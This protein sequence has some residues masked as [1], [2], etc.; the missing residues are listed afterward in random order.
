MIVRRYSK[1]RTADSE[2]QPS[3]VTIRSYLIATGLLAVLTATAHAQAGVPG[4]R[5]DAARDQRAQVRAEAYISVASFLSR[6]RA[7]WDG[8][9]AAELVKL[10]TE[11]ASVRLPAQL[12]VRGRGP[13]TAML[14][15][16]VG[17]ASSP[18]MSDLDFD[19]NGEI[20]TV[21]SCYF[22]RIDDREVTGTVTSVLYAS[23]RTWRIRLQMFD[24]PRQA[25]GGDQR[26]T[27]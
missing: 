4:G 16:A 12:M 24:P 21:V 25:A 9:N 2:R 7:L 14:Q 5:M 22:T 8:R 13:I 27:C 3:L 6:W 20:A 23:G 15:T 17:S 11:D 1:L 19:S 26:F 18:T 10:Y